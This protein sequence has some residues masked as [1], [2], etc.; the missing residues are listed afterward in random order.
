MLIYFKVTCSAVSLDIR[1]A[2]SLL[3]P[4]R[5]YAAIGRSEENVRGS[6]GHVCP[7]GLRVAVKLVLGVVQRKANTLSMFCTPSTNCSNLGGK[8]TLVERSGDPISGI[9]WPSDCS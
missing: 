4:P 3:Q 5:L 8:I 9:S 1:Q 6:R 2:G 7:P